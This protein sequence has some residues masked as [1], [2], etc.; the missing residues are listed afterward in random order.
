MTERERVRERER[1]REREREGERDR[2][3]RPVFTQQCPSEGSESREAGPAFP[4]RGSEKLAAAP[5][6]Y[7]VNIIEY[8][9]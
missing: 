1:M 5:Q 2:G 4:G 8:F 9:I 7:N 3:S 6:R